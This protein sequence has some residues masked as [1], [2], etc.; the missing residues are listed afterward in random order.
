MVTERRKP[1]PKKT[2]EPSPA[3]RESAKSAEKP[4]T[5]PAAKAEAPAPTEAGRAAQGAAPAPKETAHPPESSKSEV[6]R[7]E[8][9]EIR[10]DMASQE[11]KSLLSRKPI[12][13]GRVG[14]YVALGALTGIVP[15][16]LLPD[17]GSKRVRGALAFDLAARHG[18]SLS[19]EARK[20]L[21]EPWSSSLPRSVVAQAARFFLGR[22]VSRLGP[23]GFFSPICSGITTF[24][25][26][27]LFERYLETARVERAI[28]I[29]VEE[30]RKVR[31]AMDRALLLV[32][33][34]K[35]EGSPWG[36]APRPPEDF[37]T[38]AMQLADG[39]LFAAAGIPEWLVARLEAA[40]DEALANVGSV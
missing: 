4:R 11:P 5:A 1:R 6:R 36:F 21:E 27:L 24:L 17:I 16:P 18:L 40:F 23:L 10:D 28:R 3:P 2:P 33:T 35:N 8:R 14:A 7:P 29:D 39:V 30:A 25:F 9:P 22:V 38:S 20:V 19:N 15:L 32:F 13:A 31:K 37:R 12:G 34:V 26:G